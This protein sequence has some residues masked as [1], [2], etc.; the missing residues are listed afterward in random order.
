MFK[1]IFLSNDVIKTIKYW[2]ASNRRQAIIANNDKLKL[3]SE[4]HPS[5]RINFQNNWA[6]GWK[7]TSVGHGIGVCFCTKTLRNVGRIFMKEQ[8]SLPLLLTMIHRADSK[9][10][11]SQWEPSLQSNGVSHWLGANQES[12]LINISYLSS[13]SSG[14]IEYLKTEML[15][16]WKAKVTAAEDGLWTM[17]LISL[18]MKIL[19]TG[20]V[21]TLAYM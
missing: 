16:P 11:P 1:S 4:H 10:A 12:V 7:L 2:F 9:F 18:G 13:P 15:L 19:T 8:F 14:L 5:V 3:H 6:C 17:L 20:L 21:A